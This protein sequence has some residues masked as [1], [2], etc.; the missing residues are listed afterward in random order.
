M[1]SG[2]VPC[3]ALADV[4]PVFRHSVSDC[5]SKTRLFPVLSLDAERDRVSVTC[6]RHRSWVCSTRF[7]ESDGGLCDGHFSVWQI[8]QALK[9]S[10]PAV[11]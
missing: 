5:D 1:R 4:G 9:A 8:G 3:E 6:R 2:T 10:F 11:F 7:L